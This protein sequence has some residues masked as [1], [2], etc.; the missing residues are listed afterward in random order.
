MTDQTESKIKRKS[1]LGWLSL[2]SA[3]LFPPFGALVAIVLA[4]V[5]ITKK[6]FEN[7]VAWV[8]LIFGTAILLIAIVPFVMLYRTD[9]SSIN[10]RSVE[11]GVSEMIPGFYLYADEAKGI[12]I[13]FPDEPEITNL[14]SD[15]IPITHWSA[16]RVLSETELI[17]YKL[18]YT[19]TQIFSSASI[20]AYLDIYPEGRALGISTTSKILSNNSTKFKGLPAREYTFEYEAYGAL[21][22]NRGLVFVVDGKPIDLLVS[23][24][25]TID[26][27]EVHFAEFIDS[28]QID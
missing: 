4:I 15:D 24:H 7:T 23:Y 8:G 10:P 6:D 28:F 14:E 22:K 2:V 1:Y 19:D 12:S 3:F 17:E 18:A 16:L 26:D 9:S 21:I 5:S 25:D 11:A 20:E 13:F 27:S